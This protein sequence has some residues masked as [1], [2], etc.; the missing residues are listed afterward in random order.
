MFCCFVIFAGSRNN[1][2]SV[3]RYK[4]DKIKGVFFTVLKKRQTNTFLIIIVFGC[5][6]STFFSFHQIFCR[7]SVKNV[8]F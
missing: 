4:R 6:N 8:D 2:I 5:K 3:F 1:G 7:K